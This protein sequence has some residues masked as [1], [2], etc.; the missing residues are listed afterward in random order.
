MELVID[1]DEVGQVAA[2]YEPG[3]GMEGLLE[4]GPHTIRRASDVEPASPVK[5]LA[6]RF[7]RR[8]FGERGAVAGWTRRWN[9]PWAVSMA[10]SGGPGRLGVYA[11]RSVALAAERAWLAEGGL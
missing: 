3:L 6:F 2:M 7:L 9:G 11:E 5:R 10:R 4:Q 1:I 8:L